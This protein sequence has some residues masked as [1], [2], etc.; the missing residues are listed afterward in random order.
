MGVALHIPW[1]ARVSLSGPFGFTDQH[2]RSAIQYLGKLGPLAAPSVPELVRLIE[3]W[4]GREQRSIDVR[5]FA[6]VDTLGQIGPGAKEAV[7]LLQKLVRRRTGE[8]S[9]RATEALRR[10]TA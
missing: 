5:V 7:P 2:S 8:L 1:T 3:E 4:H 10:I 6:I 9:K